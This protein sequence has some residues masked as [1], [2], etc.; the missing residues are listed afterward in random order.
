METQSGGYEYPSRFAVLIH[1][2][3][4][5]PLVWFIATLVITTVIMG[6]YFVLQY[7]ADHRYPG[8]GYSGPY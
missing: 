3:A 6:G 5:S 1:T 4:E 8:H 2:L 7:L